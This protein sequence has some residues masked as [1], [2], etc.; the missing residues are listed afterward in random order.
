VRADHDVGGG[1]GVLAWDVEVAGDVVA[2]ARR[3]DAEVHLG[4]RQRLDGHVDHPVA[5]DDDQALDAVGDGPTGELDR[6][7][8]VVALQL[9]DVEARLAQPWE[10]DGRGPRA[11]SLPGGGVGQQGDLSG[12]GAED[13]RSATRVRGAV[14]RR[15]S[16]VS[17]PPPSPAARDSRE[18]GRR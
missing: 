1:L 8:T 7:G 16:P 12:H 5:A 2:G 13:T 14:P 6:L 11:C 17:H 15:T 9:A 10:R 4:V 18:R 3:D